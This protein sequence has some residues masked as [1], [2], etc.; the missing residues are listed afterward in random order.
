MQKT[1]PARQSNGQFTHPL[2]GTYKG[3]AV[4]LVWPTLAYVGD[5]A[6]AFIDWLET[7]IAKQVGDEHS[8]A[9]SQPS[10]KPGERFMMIVRGKTFT[11][12]IMKTFSMIAAAKTRWRVRLSVDG[13]PLTARSKLPEI[14]ITYE[15]W[16]ALNP[17]QRRI[18]TIRDGR[19]GETL[20]ALI[21]GRI[22][23]QITGASPTVPLAWEIYTPEA[24]A[25]FDPPKPKSYMLGYERDPIPDYDC[26]WL[27]YPL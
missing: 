15:Q 24:L 26:P 25:A 20:R 8:P 16:L 6:F 21:D 23:V 13:A 19:K 12:N 22:V 1:I 4:E 27:G 14:V 9:E 17:Y 18:V 5:D 2:P 7:A 11:V 10:L 3:G